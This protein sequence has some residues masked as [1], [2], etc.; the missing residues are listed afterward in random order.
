MSAVAIFVHHHNLYKSQAH[1][2][3][4]PGMMCYSSAITSL[5]AAP[6]NYTILSLGREA[7]CLCP[8]PGCNSL[9]VSGPVLSLIAWGRGLIRFG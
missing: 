9:G 3:T 5:R 1:V 7:V 6:R 8:W 4:L 2:L